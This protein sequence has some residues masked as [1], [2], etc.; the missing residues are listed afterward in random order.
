MVMDF[1]T[2]VHVHRLS[3][4]DEP[5]V[6]AVIPSWEPENKLENPWGAPVKRRVASRQATI[7]KPRD[8]LVTRSGNADHGG[9]KTSGHKP[10]LA[11]IEH[12]VAE[13]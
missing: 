9:N 2:T 8:S 3:T 13:V 7:N 5:S 6:T 4:G 12:P 1:V 10:A 11:S